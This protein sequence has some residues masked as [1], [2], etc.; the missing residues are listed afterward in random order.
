MSSVKLD[1]GGFDRLEK[2]TKAMQKTRI[3]CSD[4]DALRKADQAKLATEALQ[5]L[6]NDEAAQG[7]FGGRKSFSYHSKVVG[8]R[9]TVSR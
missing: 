9:V 8:A 1:M 4:E 6:L 3:E 2:L 7:A 5:Q